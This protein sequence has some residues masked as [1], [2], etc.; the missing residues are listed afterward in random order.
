MEL[1]Y[2][3]D[4]VPGDKV[5]GPS[6]LMVEEDMVAFAKEWDPLPFHIDREAGRKAFGSITASGTYVMAVKIK[7][8]HGLPRRHAIIASGGYDE[9]RF[10][11]PVR[12]GD[13]LTIGMAWV[14]KRESN[15]KPDRGVVT[16]RFTLTNQD[17]KIVLSHLDNIL[18]RKREPA[19]PAAPA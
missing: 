8:V 9:V 11:E 7:L 4:V 5:T 1:R 2:F 12:P 19:P 15:S 18:V 3:E 10:H 6:M 16:L 13:T 14:S 17:G